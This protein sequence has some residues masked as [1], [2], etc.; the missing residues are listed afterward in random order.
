MGWSAGKKQVAASHVIFNVVSWILVLLFLQ[1]LNRIFIHT[2]SFPQQAV[3]ALAFFQLFYNI[4][5]AIIFYPFVGKLSYILQKYIRADR[6]HYILWVST[7]ELTEIDIWIPVLQKDINMLLKKIFKFNVH[8]LRI[9]QRVLLKKDASFDTKVQLEYVLSHDAFSEDYSVLKEIEESLLSFILKALR[10]SDLTPEVFTSLQHMY[11][12]VEY[13]MYAAKAWKDEQNTLFSLFQSDNEFVKCHLQDMKK[14]M[15]AL[16]VKIAEI[17]DNT[18]IKENYD[19]IMEIISTMKEENKIFLKN[20]G[21]YLEKNSLDQW[22]LT[23]LFHV[24]QASERSHDAIWN[25]IKKLFLTDEQIKY[26]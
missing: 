24:S 13:M 14:N 22:L 20:M 5:G 4:V 11:D 8:H 10:Q 19:K 1:P 3:A 9:D 12:G 26:S 23:A 16:Y 6:P 25:A 18:N 15:V 2:F 7:L 17:I 21:V